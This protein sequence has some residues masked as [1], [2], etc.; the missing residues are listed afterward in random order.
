LLNPDDQYWVIKANVSKQ[1]D[2]LADQPCVYKINAVGQ[3]PPLKLYVTYIKDDPL[4][5]SAFKDKHLKDL[6]IEVYISD[7]PKLEHK[8][9]KVFKNPS[10]V[11]VNNV[12][13]E[14]FSTFIHLVFK[15]VYGCSIAIKARFNEVKKE[16]LPT[17][18]FTFVEDIGL[19]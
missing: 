15:S 7:E 17:Y 3:E 12:K 8:P 19:S 2:I 6:K 16:P 10:V 1:I 18:N 14:P 4:T 5:K 9:I 11:I 13:D